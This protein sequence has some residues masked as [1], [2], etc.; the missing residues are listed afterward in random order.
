LI[1]RRS[2]V[3]SPGVSDP[4]WLDDMETAETRRFIAVGRGNAAIREYH[5]GGE[6]DC[7][8]TGIENPKAVMEIVIKILSDRSG[9]DF[10]IMSLLAENLVRLMQDLR[11]AAWVIGSS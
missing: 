6:Q 2:I 8:S 1:K 3:I 5:H 9:G 4:I 7:T 10:A 11:N